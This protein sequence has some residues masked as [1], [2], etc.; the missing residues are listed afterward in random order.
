MRRSGGSNNASANL[1]PRLLTNAFE[2]E[3]DTNLLIAAAN[4]K[5]AA[6][7]NAKRALRK[8]KREAGQRDLES[9]DPSARPRH[10]KRK[11]Q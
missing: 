11:R 9:R 4:S 8:F 10:R 3:V 2:R 6:A 7:R 5:D 1:K